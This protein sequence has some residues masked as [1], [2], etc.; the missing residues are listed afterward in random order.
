MCLCFVLVLQNCK[1]KAEENTDSLDSSTLVSAEAKKAEE[2]MARRAS[3]EKVRLEKEE[4]RRLAIIE[5]AKTNST[6]KD[7]SGKVIYLKAEVDPSY[8]GGDEA[9]RDYLHANLK[10]PEPALQNGI[11]GT[12]FVDFVVDEKGS[13]RDVVATDVAGEGIDESL[14]AEAVRVVAAMPAWTA[15]TQHGKAVDA[16]YSIPITFQMN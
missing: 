3:L 4:Q 10:Y 6:Y 12:V 14:K 8:V 1:P 5:R 16:A 9:M 11:E 15:G 7:A 2:T 13:V